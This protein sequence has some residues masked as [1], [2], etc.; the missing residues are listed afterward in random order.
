M[1]LKTPERLP[2]E[3]VIGLRTRTVLLR[4]SSIDAA[5]QMSA[6]T[7]EQHFVDHC[8]ETSVS[9]SASKDESSYAVDQ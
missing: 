9:A 6:I 7:A 4:A 3:A 5:E 8:I 2:A 1:R